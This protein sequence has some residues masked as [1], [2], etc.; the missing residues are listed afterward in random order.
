MSIDIEHDGFRR[1][2]ADLST[3]AGETFAASSPR[4]FEMLVE[5]GLPVRVTLHPNER[6]VVTD[7]YAF[8]AAILTGP[9][10]TTS[11]DVLL[12]L[13]HAGLRGRPFA[14]GLDRRDLVAISARAPLAELDADTF[15]DL[16]SYLVR[17]SLRIR[18]LLFRLTPGADEISYELTVAPKTS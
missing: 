1:L 18:T 16:L 9:A 7:V 10:R 8:D 3:G 11:V 14:V 15:A 2:L 6:D 17:Q 12:T 13:N 4:S 5:E